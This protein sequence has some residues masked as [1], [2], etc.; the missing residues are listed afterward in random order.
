M[1]AGRA[2]LIVLLAVSCVPSGPPPGPPPGVLAEDEPVSFL[3]ERRDSLRLSDAV[4]NELVRMNARL[5]RRNQPLRFAV[6]TMLENAGKSRR[7]P[8]RQPQALPP[9]LQER[10]DPLLAQIRLQADAMRDTAYALLTEDQR[11]RAEELRER[12]RLLPGDQPT[13]PVR[14]DF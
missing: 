8:R 12:A 6:D 11:T 9:E 13:R 3:L 10:I 4:A 5:F 14:R 7:D 2:I 1:S